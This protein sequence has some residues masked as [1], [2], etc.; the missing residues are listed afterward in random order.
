M[1]ILMAIAAVCAVFVIFG[2]HSASADEGTCSPAGYVTFEQT[3]KD[4]ERL[5]KQFDRLATIEASKAAWC[6]ALR[7]FG[8]RDEKT[9]EA[10]L[11]LSLALSDLYRFAEARREAEAVTPF[12]PTQSGF[13]SQLKLAALGKADALSLRQGLAESELRASRKLALALK[14]EGKRFSIDYA[15]PLAYIYWL[16]PPEVEIPRLPADCR[17]SPGKEQLRAEDQIVCESEELQP[18]DN[19]DSQR[20]SYDGW[21]RAYAAAAGGDFDGATRQLT[22][23]LAKYDVNDGKNYVLA[24]D[25]PVRI[26]TLG[27]LLDNQRRRPIVEAALNDLL[28]S[29]STKNF[30]QFL[31]TNPCMNQLRNDPIIKKWQTESDSANLIVGAMHNE[32]IRGFLIEHRGLLPAKLNPP[33]SDKL[34]DDVLQSP[35]DLSKFVGMSLP[36]NED[37]VT[38]RLF[39]DHDIVRCV[40]EVANAPDTQNFI[41]SPELSNSDLDEFLD[42]IFQII[43]MY[44]TM[45]HQ[46]GSNIDIAGELISGYVFGTAVDYTGCS[47]CSDYIFES[48]AKSVDQYFVTENKYNPLS[49]IA[50]ARLASY[51]ALRGD[52]DKAFEWFQKYDA[53]VEPWADEELQNTL[54]SRRAYDFQGSRGQLID[55]LVQLALK[56]PADK[57][58]KAVKLAADALLEWRSALEFEQAVA[59]KLNSN[60]N[61]P[62]TSQRNLLAH[63]LA[64]AYST[65][66]AQQAQSS[67]PEQSVSGLYEDI[68]RYNEQLD[69]INAAARTALSSE[70]QKK[71]TS[72]EALQRLSEIEVANRSPGSLSETTG[73]SGRTAY[74]QFRAYTPLD[75]D[76]NKTG[77]PDRWAALVLRPNQAPRIVDLAMVQETQAAIDRVRGQTSQQEG[78]SGNPD[79]DLAQ[80]DLFNKLIQPLESAIGDAD[81]IYVVAPNELQWV[82]FEW[83]RTGE[84][85]WAQTPARM[86]RY[87][88]APTSLRR[89]TGGSSHIIDRGSGREFLAVGA[90]NYGGDQSAGC[91]ES[92][93]QTCP[94]CLQCLRR[95]AGTHENFCN[96]PDAK[97]ELSRIRKNVTKTPKTPFYLSPEGTNNLT[98]T[99]LVHHIETK[100]NEIFVTHIATHGF[101]YSPPDKT[102]NPLLFSGIALSNANLKP[103][104]DDLRA[105]RSDSILRSVEIENLPLKGA[106]L[107]T[108]SACNTASGDVDPAEG[109]LG[110]TRALLVAGAKNI[111]TTRAEICSGAAVDLFPQFYEY[112]GDLGWN[113]DPA[114]ALYLFRNAL[115]QANSGACESKASYW[116][117]YLLLEN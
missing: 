37:S 39:A 14:Q 27:M 13:L 65:L 67:E 112:W 19:N 105:D 92:V 28:Q 47:Y 54:Q 107:I 55:Y 109:V 4:A 61:K 106:M 7:E 20:L 72:S 98:K 66:L 111:L 35:P 116:S 3:Q 103:T 12:E 26:L 59:D 2:S 38:A 25:N 115:I 100:S 79:D 113:M 87:L 15:A 51:S 48:L 74:V 5:R 117:P 80:T 114:I 82:S 16:N 44:A 81:V 95:N 29:E 62:E 78:C 42:T 64:L 69:E 73:L 49:Q 46:V 56:A 76:F 43:K 53:T 93:S 108:L 84:H 58:A 23:L 11:R 52:Y 41:S 34:L 50:F 68:V 83:L 33:F 70:P 97:A 104:P 8:E 21:L 22:S 88:A 101:Y 75:F 36:D 71:I 85:I 96:V 94:R 89:Q 102:Y 90:E 6:L 32:Q 17:N 86:I 57:S 91:T 40:L 60:P 9:I 77:E 10:R 99:E 24:S 30:G 45:R 63:R 31:R 1:K 18:A 110:P